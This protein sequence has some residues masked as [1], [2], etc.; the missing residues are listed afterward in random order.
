[1]SQACEIEDLRDI[2]VSER[3]IKGYKF[4][5]RVDN[6]LKNIGIE[7]I[8]NPLQNMKLWK[9]Y[10]RVGSDFKIPSLNWELEAK[11]SEAK[12]F[13]SWIERDYIPRFRVGSF[14][15]TVY[16]ETMKWTTS[17]L[18][19]CFIHDIYLIEIGYLRYVLKAEMK[20][21]LEANKVLEPNSS[22]DIEAKNTKKQDTKN[23]NIEKQKQKS[24]IEGLELISSKS[25]ATFKDKFKTKLAK[26]GRFLGE[27][28]NLL[29]NLWFD[30]TGN[31]ALTKKSRTFTWKPKYG[32]QVAPNQFQMRLMK[33]TYPCEY[34]FLVW[35][36][37]HKKFRYLCKLSSSFDCVFDSSIRLH[38]NGWY[39]FCDED[40]EEYCSAYDVMC[41]YNMDREEKCR[42]HK[43]RMIEKELM[44][45][46]IE[47]KKKSKSSGKKMV[48]VS[49]L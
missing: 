18:E 31:V 3:D 29:S 43:P 10:Q 4:E 1:M 28:M 24:E 15:V 19:K 9:R 14:R 16:N 6:V 49:R 45:K 2:N 32:F 48:K 35:C 26:I 36:T 7:Y 20:H 25:S 12:I 39:C 33:Q 17:S 5:V 30:K 44:A 22:K 21:R 37:E 8:S 38:K 23:Q 27:G 40:P 13:P 47:W 41:Y 34:K 46:A 11:Y 42:W